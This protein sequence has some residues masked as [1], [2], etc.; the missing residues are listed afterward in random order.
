M[1]FVAI[2]DTH[3]RHRSLRL[4]KGDV[5]L[6]AGDISYKGDKEEVKD[7]T[8]FANGF[9]TVERRSDTTVFNVLRFGQVVGWYNPKEKFAFYYYLDCPGSNEVVAQRGRF[10]KWNAETISSFI[11]KIKGN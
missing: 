9:Y 3:C 11:K 1:R 5:L 4:P 8:R 10:E 6:H 2:S 7:M